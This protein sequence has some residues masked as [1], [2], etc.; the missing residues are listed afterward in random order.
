MRTQSEILSD[1]PDDPEGGV[2][3][4]PDDGEGDVVVKA[5]LWFL[6]LHE[7]VTN[8]FARFLFAHH[9]KSFFGGM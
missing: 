2:R 6:G 9:L 5:A 4:P 1:Q 8:F 7:I 3:G